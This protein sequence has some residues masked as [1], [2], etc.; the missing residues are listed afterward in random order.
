MT[1]RE[2]CVCW[3]MPSEFGKLGVLLSEVGI[4]PKF[5]GAVRVLDG[6]PQAEYRFR[7]KREC[8]YVMFRMFGWYY[9]QAGRKADGTKY[10]PK[11]R[12]EWRGKIPGVSAS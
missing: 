9:A 2:S 3:F 1:K 5:V 11:R 4:T 8:D 6:V 12:Y 7:T 10:Y